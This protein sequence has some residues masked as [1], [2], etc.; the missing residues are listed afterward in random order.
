[1]DLV[2]ILSV[3]MVIILQLT[4]S[5]VEAQLNPLRDRHEQRVRPK[6][7]LATNSNGHMIGERHKNGSMTLEVMEEG[8]SMPRRKLVDA[9]S[10]DSDIQLDTSVELTFDPPNNA[11][12]PH[13]LVCMFSAEKSPD[14]FTTKQR[15]VLLLWILPHLATTQRV[16][17]L[18]SIWHLRLAPRGI[19]F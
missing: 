9:I 11:S 3:I 17:L 18:I 19:A 8:Y 1:M 14:A 16:L 2:V 5:Q 10:S 15:T 12:V 4:Q 6:R 13:A 7:R